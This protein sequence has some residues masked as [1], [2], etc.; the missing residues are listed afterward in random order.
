[1][2]DVQIA[3]VASDF[4]VSAF[5]AE[6]C[7]W[8]GAATSPVIVEMQLMMMMR[9]C[10]GGVELEVDIRYCLWN[11]C[12]DDAVPCGCDYFYCYCGGYYYCWE[13]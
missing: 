5:S 10:F 8:I 7:S 2:A 9:V 3:G 1:V 13:W 11:C 4:A 6:Y 12:D